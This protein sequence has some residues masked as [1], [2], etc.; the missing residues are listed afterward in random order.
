MII[1]VDFDGTL[2][3][4]EYPRIG[5]EVPFAFETLKLWMGQGHRLIL[6][7]MRSGEKLKEAVDF[8]MGRGVD[9][10]GV[11][12]NPEQ[13]EWTDSPKVYAHQ[14]IDDAAYGCPLIKKTG[15]RPYVDWSS[16]L[17]QDVDAGLKS[18]DAQ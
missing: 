12:Q 1:A 17:L 8:C 11:N 10:W 7:T 15:A 13:H 3:E 18:E 5:P 9:F 4:H 14:Y 16:L 2:V 6:Y